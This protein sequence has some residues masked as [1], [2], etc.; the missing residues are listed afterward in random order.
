M[1]YATLD[2]GRL[3]RPPERQG[4][5]AP[6][7]V[8]AAPGGQW[9]VPVAVQLGAGVVVGVLERVTGK[10]LFRRMAEEPAEGAPLGGVVD[11]CVVGL[12]AGLA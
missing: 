12:R 3:L 6:R 1:A 2:V 4:H 8:A 7:G 5:A 10:G 9:A 11:F